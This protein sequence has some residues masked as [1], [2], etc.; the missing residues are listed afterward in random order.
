[1]FKKATKKQCKLRAGFMGIAG[2][3]KTFSALR[4][5]TGLGGKIAVID[6]ERKSA[7][8]YADRFD[9][10]VCELE[11]PT[12]EN[13]VKTIKEAEKLGYNVLI[14]DSLT[15]AW[16]MLLEE[17]EKLTATRFEGNSFRAWGIATPIQRQFI[18]VILKSNMHIITTM[19]AKTE[20]VM[21]L[22]H[23][24][25][26]APKR[27]GLSAEQGKDIE[28]EFDFLV[29]IDGNHSAEIIKDRSGKFQDEYLEQITEE[30]GKSLA[31]WLEVGDIDTPEPTLTPED[32]LKNTL[33]LHN[34]NVKDFCNHFDIKKSNIAE[35][36]III[37]AMVSEY[38][39]EQ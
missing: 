3:G 22:N 28:Y 17:V 24:G 33:A 2:S 16:K 26:Q 36:I 35:K 23:K 7:S 30:T 1:M 14:I 10:D 15:H 34:I 18:D 31:D 29:M 38:I 9:F 13:M 4:L 6:T 39:N 5:A 19:R 12:I 25:K 27:V 37:D 20:Y 11:F 21:E 32:I 8:K